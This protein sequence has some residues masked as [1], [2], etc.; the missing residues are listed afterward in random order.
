MRICLRA[1]F[2][3]RF[4]CFCGCC[5]AC[6]VCSSFGSAA[7]VSVL[8]PGACGTPTEEAGMRCCSSIGAVCASQPVAGG[9][10]PKCAARSATAVALWN[11]RGITTGLP[12]SAYPT[13]L[14][15]R[16]LGA[17]GTPAS[18]ARPEAGPG[19]TSLTPRWLRPTARPHSPSARSPPTWRSQRV[20]LRSSHSQLAR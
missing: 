8:L 11:A 20:A 9:T 13:L 2:D 7:E 17:E 1:F 3:F 12:P 6:G 18:Q 4:F 15:T 14:G 5:G 10:P 16:N 19:N